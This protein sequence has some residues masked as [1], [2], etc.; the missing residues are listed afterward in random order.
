[1][2]DIFEDDFGDFSR[3]IYKDFS[4]TDITPYKAT[5]ITN[6]A[7]DGAVENYNYSFNQAYVFNNSVSGSNSR[8]SGHISGMNREFI[9]PVNE[10]IE[11]LHRGTFPRG[12]KYGKLLISSF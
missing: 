10:D 9:I 7:S 4:I 3:S 6:T 5:V 8:L 2:A 11:V 1:M 12:S